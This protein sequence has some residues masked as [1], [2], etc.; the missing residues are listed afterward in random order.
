MRIHPTVG[1]FGCQV[2]CDG[3]VDFVETVEVRHQLQPE[4]YLVGPVVVSNTRLQ[5]N[6]QVLLIFGAELCPDDLLEAVGLGVDE[7]GVLRNW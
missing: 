4:G 2:R 1:D 7:G 3:D 6:M 5:A